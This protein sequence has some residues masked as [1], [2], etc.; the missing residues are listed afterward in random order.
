M[1]LPRAIQR[2]RIDAVLGRGG[3]GE[4]YRAYDPQLDR[5]V[6]LKVLVARQPVPGLGEDHQTLDLRAGGAAG[7]ELLAEARAM[8]QVSDP[9]V[10]PIYEIGVDGRDMFLVMELVEGV[11]LAEWLAT[12]RTPAAI[13]DVFVQAARGLAAAHARGVVHR[14]FKPANVLVGEDGRARVADFGIAALVG[15]PVESLVRVD[16]GAGTPHYMAPELWR[17]EPATTRSD[18]YAFAIA[19]VEA[20]GG[21]L[22]TATTKLGMKLSSPAA[23]AIAAALSDTPS[24]RPRDA[25][26]LVAALTAKRSRAAYVAGGALAASA[27]AGVTLAFGLHSPTIPPPACDPDPARFA[28]RWDVAR[29]AQLAGGGDPGAPGAQAEVQRAL[30]LGDAV[31]AEDAKIRIA[32][33]RAHAAGTLA[34]AQLAKRT[35]CLDRRG[36]ELAARVSFVASSKQREPSLLVNAIR[37]LTVLDRCAVIEGTPLTT[38]AARVA[39]QQLYER[40]FPA[41]DMRPQPSIAALKPIVEEATRA[42]DFELASRAA[43]RLAE[44]LSTTPGPEVDAMLVEAHRLANA[45]H[46]D[47]AAAQALLERSKQALRRYDLGGARAVAE[48]ALE[49]VDRPYIPSILRAQIFHTAGRAAQRRGDPVAALSLLERGLAA[50][51]LQA[52]RTSS[53][54]IELQ[55]DQ[56][57]ALEEIEGTAAKRDR[58]AVETLALARTRYHGTGPEFQNALALAERAAKAVGDHARAQQY[59]RMAL[60]AT[61]A[62]QT[63]TPATES[64]RRALLAVELLKT[65]RFEEAYAH[66]TAAAK[67]ALHDPAMAIER[68]AYVAGAAVA[69]SGL[70]RLDEGNALLEEVLVD[71]TARYGKN[72]TRTTNIVEM[73]ASSELELGK[74]DSVERRIETLERA[75]GAKSVPTDQARAK[76][77]GE[78][79]AKLKLLRGDA[80]GAEELARRSLAS[81]DELG[82]PREMKSATQRVRLEALNEL[83]R[84]AEARDLANA[85]L[86]IARAN[87]TDPSRIAMLELELARSEY[88]LGDRKQ[89]LARA[90]D[91]APV[92]EKWRSSPTAH[93]K[94]V[95]LLARPK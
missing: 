3:M 25:G 67:A 64:L 65:G 38:P 78:L 18:V 83:G 34:D 57:S 8:A 81:L 61:V 74:L 33:C 44:K 36:Y 70:G 71:F 29:K 51:D 92:L 68:P 15:R 6:A 66:Y 4:V 48:L 16:P 10:L 5:A 94:L 28:G 75:L 23:R 30:A 87:V 17:D 84:Y 93:A 69:L 43:T 54:R 53:T 9:H 79:R 76:L 60:D 35:A 22:T 82:V 56:L 32:N 62:M 24:A 59:E 40:F 41:V 12:P 63:F 27:V 26:V 20:L 88:G 2:F 14:D 50:I 31:V 77:A 1:T 86:V 13:L 47:A 72:H 55:L 58:I 90:H 21:T 95:E 19:F 80:A 42:G 45:A 11:D 37:N 85:E 52:E 7:G 91:I 49:L 46:S 39:N 73:I 89:A